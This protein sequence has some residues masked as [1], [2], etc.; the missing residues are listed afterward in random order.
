MSDTEKITINL[1]AVDLGKIDLL[2]DQGLYSNRTD[3]IRTAIRN[4]LERHGE[5]VEQAVTRR[6]M[7][8]GVLVHCA[9][10]L[11]EQKRRGRKLRLGVVGMLV[12][13]SDVT[14]ELAS[15]TIEAIDLFGV[16]RASPAVKEALAG[17]VRQFATLYNR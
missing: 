11:E 13:T 12:L 14:P 9:N 2:V 16:F 7:T 6:E 1:G 4:Q 17:R 3:L 10:D 5:V 15:E 8:V